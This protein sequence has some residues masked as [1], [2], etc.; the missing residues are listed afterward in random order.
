MSD[1]ATGDQRDFYMPRVSLVPSGEIPV[2]AEGTDFAQ[3]TFDAD[4]L[5]PANGEAIYVDGM[6]LA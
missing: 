6:P 5:K 3:M 2:I 4:V 1:N